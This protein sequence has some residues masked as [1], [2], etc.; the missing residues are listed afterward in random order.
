VVRHRVPSAGF[1]CSSSKR[2]AYPSESHTCADHDPCLSLAS[3]RV[4]G[5]AE[6]AAAYGEFLSTW[7]EL[8][9]G[10]QEYRELVRRRGPR[11]SPQQWAWQGE[12]Y[13]GRAANGHRRRSE[14]VHPAAR[15]RSLRSSS[16][17][18]ASGRSPTSASHRRQNEPLPVCG[19]ATQPQRP[20][21]PRLAQAR[22]FRELAARPEWRAGGR[23]LT[24][25]RCAT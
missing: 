14:R 11:V 6:M 22:S 10:W 21:W 23:L 17:G 15:A 2:R 19:V 7:D 9:N 13:G 18:T 4:T 1:R 3:A 16:T 5:V 20:R 24:P 12:R 8:R 25:R